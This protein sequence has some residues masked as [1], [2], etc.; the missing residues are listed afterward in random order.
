ME[1]KRSAR[2]YACAEFIA[3]GERVFRALSNPMNQ[4]AP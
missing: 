3:A 1:G 2:W 4:V